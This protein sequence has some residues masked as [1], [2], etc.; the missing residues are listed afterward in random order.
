MRN[1]LTLLLISQG[2]PFLSQGDEFGRTQ[3]GNNNAYCQD[4]E[5]S[6]V[7]W[8]AGREERRPVA[9]HAHDDRPADA[10]LR[11][12][13]GAIRQPRE[14]A[15]HASRASRTGRASGESLAFQLHGWHGQP[16]LYVIFNAHWEGQRF[17]L[18]PHGRWRWQR[19]VDT[20]LPS[21]DDIVEE[22]D[23]VWLRPADHYFL[24]P[25]SAVILI[26]QS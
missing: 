15:R 7:D 14:L 20:N 19:L 8:I 16:D 13:P 23:A 25:R 5:I 26:S 17:N 22:K 4:N 10:V 9:L 1:F 6:W 18:P 3:H 12:E 11:P 2:V 24:A 21:P